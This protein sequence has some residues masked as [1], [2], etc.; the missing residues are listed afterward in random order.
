MGQL[1]G[2]VG[3]SDGAD[4]TAWW[5]YGVSPQC[6][7]KPIGKFNDTQ[8]CVFAVADDSVGYFQALSFLKLANIGVNQVTINTYPY[9][10]LAV[11]ACLN[12]EADVCSGWGPAIDSM[13]IEG[14]TTSL[15]SEHL[16]TIYDGLFV[17]P[18][19][20]ANKAP[21]VLAFYEDWFRAVNMTR[22]N[23]P[24]AAAKIAT[25]TYQGMPTNEYTFVW[26]GSEVDDLTYWFE[27]YAQAGFS[28]QFTFVAN[29]NL[30]YDIYKTGRDVWEYSGLPLDGGF[31][32]ANMVDFSYFQALSNRTD[33]NSQNAFVNNSFSP[34]PE[35]LQPATTEE[36]IKLPTLVEIVCPN[37]SF[38]PGKS[39]IPEN[40]PEFAALLTCGE[41][42]K[43]L[44]NQSNVQILFISSAAWPD[45]VDYGQL[46]AHCGEKDEDDYCWKVALD[47]GSFVFSVFVDRLQIPPQ[48]I[49]IDYQ[50]GPK[51]GIGQGNLQE[52]RFVTIQ[53]KIGGGL[54]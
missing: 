29:R 25:W 24:E 26:Q 53:V 46:Y 10:E 22:D 17:S 49:A 28:S 47:R 36:L 21:A 42:I 39:T 23:L 15:S 3:Q 19:A 51:T 50:L 7:G 31:D 33:L 14:Q 18:N 20:D 9:P 8:G 4:K 37:V 41:Q 5:N 44:L 48:R 52:S 6:L 13:V 38:A 27:P 54:Q 2:I 45:P 30:I 35:Q 16:K 1:I 11:A 32:P 40:T 43:T 34:F 12:S